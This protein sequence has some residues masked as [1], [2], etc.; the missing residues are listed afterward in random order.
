[1]ILRYRKK[2]GMPYP[3]AFADMAFVFEEGR[4]FT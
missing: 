4:I 1:M 3:Q 2:F